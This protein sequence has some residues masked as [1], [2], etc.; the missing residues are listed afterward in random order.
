MQQIAEINVTG[1][2]TVSATP[3]GIQIDLSVISQNTDYIQTLSRLNERVTTIIHAVAHAGTVETV[4]TKSYAISEQWSD[5]Y[6]DEKRKFQG[7]KATQKLEVTIPLDTVLLGS[8]VQELAASE[9]KANMGISFVIRDMDDLR[10]KARIKAAKKTKEAASDLAEAM[11]LQLL[12]VKTIT[13]SAN[14]GGSDT[15]L[16]LDAL[17]QYSVSPSSAVT[18]DVISHEEIVNMVWLAT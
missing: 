8:I 16:H 13:Y 4:F 6:D 18:P 14:R 17:S 10:K 12:S 5:Q 15:G 1:H 11:G 2:G 3:D 9:S 7:Y